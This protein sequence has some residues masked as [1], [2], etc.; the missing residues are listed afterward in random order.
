MQILKQD[1]NRRILDV[2]RQE[3]SHRGFTKASMRDIAA[4]VGVGV[5]NLYNYYPG[6]DELFCAVLAPVVSA[7][8]AMFDKHHGECGQDALYM[9]R[10]NYLLS[11]VADYMTILKWNRTLLKILL[12]KA[13]GSSLENFKI[14]FTD[15]ATVQVKTWFANNKLRHPDMNIEVSDFMIHLHTVWMF[16]LFEEIIMHRVTGD[17]MVRVIEEYIKFEINGWKH[18]LNIG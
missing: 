6:K 2:A 13:Q 14:E 3:F 15:R 9:T 1:I 7:C 11:A 8:Y 5:G 4:K 12:F 17:D 16:T 18:L 10:E